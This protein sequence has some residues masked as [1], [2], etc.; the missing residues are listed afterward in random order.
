LIVPKPISVKA[1]NDYELFVVFDN[2]EEKIYNMKKNFKLKFY[3]KLKNKELFKQVK[4]SGINIEWS[5]GEDLD[6]DEL[7]FNSISI[8][9]LKG[10]SPM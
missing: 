2:G 3:S 6:P 9:D 5:T 8:N 10:V 1:L 7:Y 4:T